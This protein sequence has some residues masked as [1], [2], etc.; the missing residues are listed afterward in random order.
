MSDFVILNVEHFSYLLSGIVV[1]YS[2][3]NFVEHIGTFSLVIYVEILRP[4]AHVCRVVMT[5]RESP[6][7]HLTGG[8]KS[9]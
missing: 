3:V 9:Q 2:K 7:Y 5:P 6:V 4:Q 1:K 8:R